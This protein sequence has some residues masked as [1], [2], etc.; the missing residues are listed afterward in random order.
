MI[1]VIIFDLDGLL[2]NSQPLQYKAYNHVFSKYGYPLSSDEWEEW[3]QNS[4]SANAWIKKHNLPLNPEKI[5]AEKKEI[6]DQLIATELNLMPGARK[7][8]RLLSKKYRLCIASSS[9]IES[10]KAILQKFNL[11]SNFEKVLS[12]TEMEKG[13]PHPHIFLKMA[14]LMQVSPQECCVIE[15]SSA[16]LKAA[17]SAGMKCIVCPDKFIK[18]QCSEYQN[19]DKMVNSLEEINTQNI[20][21]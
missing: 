19:A 18:K 17:K 12:D 5:R 11:D 4:Y 6:Y 20:L 1:K 16:G 10:V 2:V 14:K 15:D 9:R 13:K 7:A 8:I 21:E 3:I